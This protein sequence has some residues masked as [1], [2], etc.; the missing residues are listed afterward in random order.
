MPDVE[1]VDSVGLSTPILAAL[2][3]VKYSKGEGVDFSITELQSP[4]RIKALEKIHAGEL[5]EEAS[6]RVWALLGTTMH[7]LLESSMEFV[8]QKNT[9]GRRSALEACLT[10]AVTNK[11]NILEL[12]EKIKAAIKEADR[13]YAAAVHNLEYE[14]RHKMT[15]E[16]DGREYVVS[17]AI[18]LFDRNTGDIEDYKLCGV[19]AVILGKDEWREQMNGYRLLAE[20]NGRKTSGKARIWAFMRDWNKKKALYEKGYPKYQVQPIEFELDPV[21]KTMEWVKN[22][23]RAHATARSL[24]EDKIPLCSPQERWAKE[25]KWAVKKVGA[26]R[27][28][29]LFDDKHAATVWLEGN[30][31]GAEKLTLEHR[32]GANVRCEDGYCLVA[33]WCPLGIKRG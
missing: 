13:Q 21:D 31:R 18:D 5:K 8:A 24:A 4:A 2:A 6:D 32:P 15:V 14:M 1:L 20:M 30:A 9:E 16:V 22:R 29:K 12:P 7:G 33:E 10:W 28:I 23:I 25:E 19:W 27:A 17:G 3:N 26:D 11:E